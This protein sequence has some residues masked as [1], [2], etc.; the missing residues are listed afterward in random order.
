M[1]FEWLRI[2]LPQKGTRLCLRLDHGGA[3]RALF[4]TLPE[5]DECAVFRLLYTRQA[6]PSSLLPRWPSGQK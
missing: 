4:Q 3:G 1:P 6:L 2:A 5:R